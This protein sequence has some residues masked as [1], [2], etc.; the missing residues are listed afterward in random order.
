MV[1]D[2]LLDTSR[3][4]KNNKIVTQPLLFYHQFHEKT[5]LKILFVP[6]APQN[7]FKLTE[8]ANYS[9]RIGDL[10]YLAGS[11]SKL[12]T[13]FYTYLLNAC[14]LVIFHFY[15]G[16]TTLKLIYKV[17]FGHD[18]LWRVVTI[19]FF[20]RSSMI[21]KNVTMEPLW[22][23]HLSPAVALKDFS[24]FSFRVSGDNFHTFS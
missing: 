8:V 12:Q 7:M 19:V 9:A 5:R 21:N 16:P 17:V 15:S 24:H 4:S 1:P 22:Q 2:Q 3:N 23:R 14:R 6:W 13:P 10:I 18:L 11:I 20:T